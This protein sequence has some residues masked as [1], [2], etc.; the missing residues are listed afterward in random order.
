MIINCRV[1][2]T[3]M[4]D[5][6]QKRCNE[7]VSDSNLFIHCKFF[8]ACSFLDSFVALFVDQSPLWNKSFLRFELLNRSRQMVQQFLSEKRFL[9]QYRNK[10]FVTFR[11]RLI[12]AF[13][14]PQRKTRQFS[15]YEQI[16]YCVKSVF[17]NSLKIKYIK[18]LS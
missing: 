15:N 18:I 16:L 5:L 3:D 8:F 9:L 13:D 4:F 14:K 2:W 11:S 17:I 1:T 6:M 10:Y 12:C 7:Q